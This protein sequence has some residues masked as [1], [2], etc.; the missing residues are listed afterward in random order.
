MKITVIGSGSSGNCYLID[1]G[2]SKIMLEC[3]LPIKKIER[4]CD[5]HLSSVSGCLVTHEHGDHIKSANDL[6]LRGVTVW[7][8]EGTAKAYHA[9]AYRLKLFQHTNGDGYFSQQIGSFCV[10][11]FKTHHDAAEPV[12][13]LLHS[14]DTNERLL[15][16]TDTPYIDYKIGR[17]DYAMVE[18]NYSDDALEDPGN[19]GRKERLLRTHM[20]IDN[21]LKLLKANNLKY[22]KHI[23]LIHLSRR[24]A[25]AEEFVRRVEAETGVPTSAA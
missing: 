14:G 19:T 16:V 9:S 15:Y 13:F 17:L 23:Y 12:G 7:M 5:Y 20:S 11:P 6:M 4:G 25:D 24:N 22:C 18:A 10:L 21:A 8:T 1:D 3:G 2:H